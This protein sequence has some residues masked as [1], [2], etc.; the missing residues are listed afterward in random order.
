MISL[1][2]VAIR[3]SPRQMELYATAIF[4]GIRS[5]KE[6][7]EK[8]W[9]DVVR[10]RIESN[11]RGEQDANGDKFIQLAE[12][13]RKQRRNEGFSEAHP[14]LR[15]TNKLFE[16][17]LQKNIWTFN[18]KQAHLNVDALT[19]RVPYAMYLQEGAEANNLPPRPYLS[20]N[21]ADAERI[22][23]IFGN[24]LMKREVVAALGIN[25]ASAR[26]AGV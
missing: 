21:E 4:A 14:I 24:Y 19:S 22:E 16:T 23:E 25:W 6:P 13:T 18:T 9:K 20:L 11:F 5:Y 12:S 3:P 10:P 1:S 17:A 26:R 8:A 15:R 7:L 2:H